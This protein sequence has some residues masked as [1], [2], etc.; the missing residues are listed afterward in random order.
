LGQHPDL[1][2]ASPAF[3]TAMGEARGHLLGPAPE[4]SLPAQ[5]GM[6]GASHTG[7]QRLQQPLQQHALAAPSALAPVLLGGAGSWHEPEAGPAG[8]SHQQQ[9]VGGSGRAPTRRASSRL[10]D[11]RSSRGRPRKKAG[12]TTSVDSD[13]SQ[14]GSLCS[15]DSGRPAADHDRAQRRVPVR[16]WPKPAAIADAGL[17]DD[18]LVCQ[19]PGCGGDLSHC[20]DYHQRHRICEVHFKAPQV[21]QLLPLG[22][23]RGR[24]SWTCACSGACTNACAPSAAGL[25]SEPCKRGASSTLCSI[26]PPTRPPAPAG[27]DARLPAAALL[28]AVPPLPRAGGL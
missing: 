5:P 11:E 25:S 15:S 20:K 21:G 6:P 16:F 23:R 1:S 10:T 3:V 26:S 13:S 2:A 9:A 22:G 27:Q 12:R 4:T 28:P 7:M 24:G 8:P 14:E 17:G 19:V 18:A